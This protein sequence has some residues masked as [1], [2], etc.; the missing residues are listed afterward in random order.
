MWS[1]LPDVQ[2]A[3]FSACPGK[4]YPVAVSVEVNLESKLAKEY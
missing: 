4:D 2:L 1:F 3:S